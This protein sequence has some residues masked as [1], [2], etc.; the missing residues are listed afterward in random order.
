MNLL[1]FVKNELNLNSDLTNNQLFINHT[2][3]T[4]Y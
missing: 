3:I 1:G 2:V 4:S